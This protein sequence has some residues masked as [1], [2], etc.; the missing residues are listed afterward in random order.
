MRGGGGGLAEGDP[1]QCSSPFLTP[2]ACEE[3]V[4]CEKVVGGQRN[5]IPYSAAISSSTPGASEDAASASRAVGRIQVIVARRH[6]RVYRTPRLPEPRSRISY[7]VD[8]DNHYKNRHR[9][10]YQDLT[11]WGECFGGQSPP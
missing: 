10:P 5:A 2:G 6:R 7:E 11:G 9:G 4:W 1:L 3:G 8:A